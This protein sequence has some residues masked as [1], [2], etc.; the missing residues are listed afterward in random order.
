MILTYDK[1]RRYSH[2]FHASYLVYDIA[3]RFVYTVFFSY[4]P[5]VRDIEAIN[6]S[7]FSIFIV[8]TCFLTTNINHSLKPIILKSNRNSVRLDFKDVQLIK[9]GPIANELVLVSDGDLY[10]I[11]SVSEV[12]KFI[13]I[14]S[15]ADKNILN[16]IANWLYEGI[17]FNVVF[18]QKMWLN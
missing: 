12:D 15:S 17:A 3:K 18:K 13:R 11:P 6:Y 8:N 5:L 7:H 2:S 1:F 16:G 10:L 4:I 14:T 9:F